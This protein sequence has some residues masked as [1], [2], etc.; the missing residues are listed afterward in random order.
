MRC[1]ARTSGGGAGVTVRA[2][3]LGSVTA[4][5]ATSIQRPHVFLPEAAEQAASSVPLG[6]SPARALRAPWEIALTSSERR[7]V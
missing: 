3:L 5:L 7:C 4:Q 2:H 6:E 1:L